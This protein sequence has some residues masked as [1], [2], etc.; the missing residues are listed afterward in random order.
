MRK[1]KRYYILYRFNYLFDGR[2]GGAFNVTAYTVDEAIL[3]A[4]DI[5]KW[6]YGVGVVD[7]NSLKPDPVLCGSVI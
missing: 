4:A 2:V 7:M 1:L 3:K 5:A 6:A